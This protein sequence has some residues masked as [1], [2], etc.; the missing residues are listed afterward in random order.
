MIQP[1]FQKQDFALCHVPVPTGYPQSQTH[2]GVLQ[3]NGRTY[4]TTSPFPNPQIE[5]SCV[6]YIKGAL[7]RLSNNKLFRIVPGEEYENPCIYVADKQDA[8]FFTPIYNNPLVTKPSNRYGLA[9]YNSDPDIC[10]ID[11]YIYILNRQYFRTPNN[12]SRI[13]IQLLKGIIN[14]NGYTLNS[15]DKIYEGEEQVVSPSMCQVA[16]RNVFCFIDTKSVNNVKEFSGIYLNTHFTL[17]NCERIVEKAVKIKLESDYQPWHLSLF[18]HKDT[19]YAIVTCI[20]PY[21]ANRLI[22]NLG[23][24]N[25]NIDSLRVLNP[26]LTTLNSYRSCAYIDN[27]DNFHFYLTTVHENFAQSS[28]VDG[29]NICLT[30]CKLQQLINK[31]Y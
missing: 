6:R 19:L 29:R 18:A 10:T 21:N 24:F 17:T 23:V 11:G 7:R 5:I 28:S 20:D 30:K 4:L 15:I 8:T 13:Q 14:E 31:L 2:A 22:Q 27:E 9:A 26:P 16:G 3:Y 1:I 12:G 25:Q